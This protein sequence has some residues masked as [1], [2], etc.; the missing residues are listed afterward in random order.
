[1]KEIRDNPIEEVK[2]L[3]CRYILHIKDPKDSIRKFLFLIN[4]FS[5]KTNIYE[6]SCLFNICNRNIEKNKQGV[7]HLYVPQKITCNK[8]DQEIE[9]F[10][11]ENF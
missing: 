9:I 6:S 4:I 2:Y 7:N 8:S 11:S 5:N 10:Y 1:M 3:Y